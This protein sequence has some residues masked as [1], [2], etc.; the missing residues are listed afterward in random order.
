VT[1]E[2]RKDEVMVGPVDNA[3]SRLGFQSSSLNNGALPTATRT[4]P[5]LSEME[6][7]KLRLDLGLPLTPVEQGTLARLADVIAAAVT[8]AIKG[9]TTAPVAA[10]PATAALPKTVKGAKTV[11]DFKLTGASKQDIA[12]FKAALAY[13]QAADSK[14]KAISPTA[15]ALLAKVPKGAKINIIKDLN[16]FYDP[17]AKAI[18][19]NPRAAGDL[20][21][22]KMSPALVLAHEIDHMVA[23]QKNPKATGDNYDNTEEKRVITGSETKIAREL[24]EPT[25]KDHRGGLVLVGSS[26]EH[27]S[28]TRK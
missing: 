27:T 26:T 4:T 10:A 5:A 9:P 15:V 16:A 11:A 28:V 6:S 3:A 18:S 21:S 24:G 2:S 22:G 20:A 8:A 14:G 23:G 1:I 7:L 13:L 17:S 19:W 12:D 25:R